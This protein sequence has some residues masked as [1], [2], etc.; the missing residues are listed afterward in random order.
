MTSA[1]NFLVFP[2]EQQSSMADADDKEKAEKV[3]AAKRR[4]SVNTAGSHFADTEC[5][6]V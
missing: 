6:P 2:E 1:R 5:D 3:A 4:V